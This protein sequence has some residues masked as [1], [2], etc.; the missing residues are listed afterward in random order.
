METGIIKYLNE[1]F[2]ISIPSATTAE[3]MELF[4]AERINRL[5]ATDFTQLVQV[6]YRIDVSEA[7]LRSM[8]KEHPD[9]DAG[10]IIAALVIQRQLEKIRSREQF[11]KADDTIDEEEKW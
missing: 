1:K 4:L 7:K 10:R 6:L 9:A 5:I 11:R 2:D 8:L 3:E